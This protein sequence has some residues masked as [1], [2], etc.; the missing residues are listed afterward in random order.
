MDWTILRNS[1]TGSLLLPDDSGFHAAVRA[2][3]FIAGDGV[4]APAAVLRCRTT[5]DVATAIGFARRHELP[6]AVRSGGHCSAG[7][8][9]TTGLVVDLSPMDTIEV[10]ESGRGGHV[11]V[12]GG[13]RLAALI[14]ALAAHDR[15]IPTG[16]CPTVGVSGLTLG[17]GWGMLSRQYGLT[18]DHL[19]RAEMVTA[20]G[21]V[22]GT[23]E[24]HEPDLFWALRGGGA[25]GFGVVTSMVFRTVP[26]PRMTNFRCTW[27]VT[28][29]AD[30]IDA[31]LDKAIDAPARLCA[32]AGVYPGEVRLF[33]AMAGT[34]SETAA[35]LAD[36]TRGLPP[37]QL[38]E[39]AELSY[40]DSA[41]ALAGP[42]DE[43]DPFAHLYAASEFFETALPEA[44]VGALL[45]RFATGP[46]QREFAFMPWGGAADPLPPDATAFPHRQARYA[47]H[48]IA[49]TA[50]A[51]ADARDWVYA[52]RDTIHDYGTGGVY[53]NFADPGLSDWE[54]AYYGD[55]TGRLREVKRRY[56]P[57]DVFGTSQSVRPH[58]DLP[59]SAL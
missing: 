32:E 36:L 56:D 53:A 28:V 19:V 18:C 12:G 13:V 27:P 46:A 3:P 50:T 20:D 43:P 15:A 33:G 40:L 52:M 29:A 22:I 24:D 10:D 57:G 4:P 16:T 54:H 47:V 58:G 23:D 14:T 30:L 9:S 41:R 17:G 35:E 39:L 26:A 7:L 42:N 38:A 59:D 51:D 6:F 1:V 2:R 37:P 31:W 25:G 45:E 11:V 48:P 34:Q 21:G 8:S 5:A 55:N 44:A 49:V